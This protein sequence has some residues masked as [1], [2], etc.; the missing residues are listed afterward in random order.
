[1]L[2]KAALHRNGG[3]GVYNSGESERKKSFD[4]NDSFVYIVSRFS[5][6]KKRNNVVTDDCA[7][8]FL[9]PRERQPQ[10]DPSFFVFM[11]QMRQSG[12]N[13]FHF[14]RYSFAFS[15]GEIEK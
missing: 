10:Q 13:G 15:G 9:T 7:H 6:D 12:H 8:I 14:P 2:Y 1:M 11:D 3:E 4:V 5:R